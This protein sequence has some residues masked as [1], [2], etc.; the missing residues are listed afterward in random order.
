MRAAA[1]GG[2]MQRRAAFTAR[3]RLPRGVVGNGNDVGRAIA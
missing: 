1:S 3:M 2:Q